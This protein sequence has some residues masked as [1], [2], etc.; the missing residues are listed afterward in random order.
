MTLTSFNNTFTQFSYTSSS[1]DTNQYSYILL[2]W[3]KCTI[4]SIVFLPRTAVF[5]SFYT[6]TTIARLLENRYKIFFRN[7]N[8]DHL[9]HMIAVISSLYPQSVDLSAQ[10]LQVCV[11]VLFCTRCIFITCYLKIPKIIAKYQW[12]FQNHSS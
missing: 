1:S 12:I 7:N 9:T 10:E 2:V 5:L 11:L 4:I 6:N 8:P 3:T